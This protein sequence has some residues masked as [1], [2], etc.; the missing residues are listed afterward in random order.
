MAGE[1]RDDV[2]DTGSAASVLADALDRFA[3]RVIARA[4]TEE[5]AAAQDA[6]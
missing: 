2:I 5:H 6:A 3:A 4:A 1:E